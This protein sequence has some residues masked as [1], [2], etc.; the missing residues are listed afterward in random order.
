TFRARAE[1]AA[2]PSPVGVD[3]PPSRGPGAGDEQRQLSFAGLKREDHLTESDLDVRA[4]QVDVRLRPQE[5]EDPAGQPGLDTFVEQLKAKCAE[6]VGLEEGQGRERVDHA[7][8][9]L[10]RIGWEVVVVPRRRSGF[11]A[12]AGASPSGRRQEARTHDPEGS[13]PRTTRRAA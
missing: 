2:P 5:V 9:S 11:Q 1:V 8:V 4:G 12:G 6:G 3:A 13:R 7:T 10:W